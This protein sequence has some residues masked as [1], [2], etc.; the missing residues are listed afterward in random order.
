MCLSSKDVKIL[1]NLLQE[2]Y[3]S[4]DATLI[5]ALIYIYEVDINSN[6]RRNKT[7]LSKAILVFHEKIGWNRITSYSGSHWLSAGPANSG[8]AVE[9]SRPK[10]SRKSINELIIIYPK[11]SDLGKE[12]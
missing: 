6:Y 11:R 2:S 5:Q 8:V 3:P 9:K 10:P 7:H 1:S 12:R 4:Y